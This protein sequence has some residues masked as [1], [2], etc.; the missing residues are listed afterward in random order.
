MYVQVFVDV[1]SESDYQFISHSLYPDI[2]LSVLQNMIT[3][4]SKVCPKVTKGYVSCDAVVALM[5][6]SRHW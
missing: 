4:N 1:L 2:D 5:C 3:F 6:R